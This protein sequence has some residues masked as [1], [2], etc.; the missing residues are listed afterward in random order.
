M[1]GTGS[2]L[3]RG[4]DSV[5]VRGAGLV[6]TRGVETEVTLLEMEE[7]VLLRCARRPILE[8]ESVRMLNTRL[9]CI[10]HSPFNFF[11]SLGLSRKSHIYTN[12]ACAYGTAPIA[13]R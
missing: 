10:V 4:A 11:V 6:S 7:D 13:I 9:P 12:C 8:S 3:V 2:V 1:R 5:L